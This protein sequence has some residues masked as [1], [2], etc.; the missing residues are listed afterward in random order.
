M[1][2]KHDRCSAH[3]TT[4]VAHSGEGLVWNA[5]IFTCEDIWP[6]VAKPSVDHLPRL[7]TG[8]VTR[9]ISNNEMA[10][11]FRLQR[12]LH[13]GGM[14]RIRCKSDNPS[15]FGQDHQALFRQ[16]LAGRLKLMRDK[17]QMKRHT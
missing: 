13:G 12:T 5:L 11:S 8:K 9:G 2:R 3:V 15:D 14:D 6:L 7:V 1:E 16:A 4:A 10:A 17:P